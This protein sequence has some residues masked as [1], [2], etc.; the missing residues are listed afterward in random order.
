MK[1]KSISKP[2]LASMVILVLFA[3]LVIMIVWIGYVTIKVAYT[4]K[5]HQNL[6]DLDFKEYENIN[7]ENDL[8]FDSMQFIL[9]VIEN[10][11]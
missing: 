10:V 8:L 3:I 4:E 5:Q 2:R 7:S 9:E 11:L 6:Q 1:I